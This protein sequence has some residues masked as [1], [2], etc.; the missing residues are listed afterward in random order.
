MQSTGQGHIGWAYIPAQIRERISHGVTAL[1]RIDKHTQFYDWR[2]VGEALIDLCESAKDQSG[3]N[4][5]IGK[6]YNAAWA[7]I[8]ADNPKLDKLSRLDSATRTNAM[9]LAKNWTA[10]AAWHADEL[11]DATRRL[12]NH[13]ATVRRRYYQDYPL[14]PRRRTGTSEGEEGE[15]PAEDEEGELEDESE[16]ET[17]DDTRDIYDLDGAAATVETEEEIMRRFED[18]WRD[19]PLDTRIRIAERIAGWLAEYKELAAQPPSADVEIVDEALNETRHIVARDQGKRVR[20]MASRKVATSLAGT[21]QPERIAMVAAAASAAD[22][23]PEDQIFAGLG[24]DLGAGRVVTVAQVRARMPKLSAIAAEI[25][26]TKL[27]HPDWTDGQIGH[28]VK[29]LTSVVRRVLNANN[30]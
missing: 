12:V 26:V 14:P 20:A 27:N 24:D 16:D 18:F 9:W 2:A 3:A 23:V 11:D 25:V 13:P 4:G 29:R 5:Y 21:P 1:T 28:Q 10:V 30:V 19:I 17:L 15:D 7:R 8:V 6:G 22:P